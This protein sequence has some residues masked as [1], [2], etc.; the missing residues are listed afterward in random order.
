MPTLGQRP[1]V[2]S[3]MQTPWASKVSTFL[4]W[5]VC[6]DWCACLYFRQQAVYTFPMVFTFSSG[7]HIE[8]GKSWAWITTL[9]TPVSVCWLPDSQKY[10][11]TYET[12]LY[13]KIFSVI[14][15][16]C[17]LLLPASI[18]AVILPSLNDAIEITFI[19]NNATRYRALFLKELNNKCK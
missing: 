5:Y 1:E 14:F 3:C 10:V 18:I 8:P 6:R 4:S 19:F 12:P 15:L 9:L 13:T 17:L 7:L 16:A 11:L 2:L